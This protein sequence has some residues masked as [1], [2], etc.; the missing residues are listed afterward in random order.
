VGS[1]IRANLAM[2]QFEVPFDDR[3]LAVA[4]YDVRRSGRRSQRSRTTI[5]SA[6]RIHVQREFLILSA[7]SDL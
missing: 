1:N 7:E 4:Y 2:S 5:S 6:Y 3:A